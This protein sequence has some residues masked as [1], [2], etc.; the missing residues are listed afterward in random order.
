VVEVEQD[1]KGPKVE[2]IGNPQDIVKKFTGSTPIVPPDAHK[3][4]LE[5][6]TKATSQPLPPSVTPGIQAIAKDLIGKNT[7]SAKALS[8]LAAMPMPALESAKLAAAQ[9]GMKNVLIGYPSAAEVARLT[10]L[11]VPLRSPAAS[12]DIAG[13]R[14]A[15]IEEMQRRSDA[16]LAEQ[17]RASR[18]ETWMLRLTAASVLLAAASVV[19]ALVVVLQ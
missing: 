11:T 16:F 2:I 19:L 13:M 8:G 7:V 1:R 14:D 3:R 5:T 12:E 6:V 4:I 15:L 18:R 10:R 9:I 17:E